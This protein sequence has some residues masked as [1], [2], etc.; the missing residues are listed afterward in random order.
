M[1]DKTLKQQNLAIFSSFVNCNLTARI[2]TELF[3]DGL[4]YDDFSPKLSN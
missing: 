1:T 2:V 4:N 3:H